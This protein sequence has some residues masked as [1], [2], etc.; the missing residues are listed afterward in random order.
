MQQRSL[1][2]NLISFDALMHA[3][4]RAVGDGA[5][6]AEMQQ[7]S[8]ASNLIS[9]DALMHA[10]RGGQWEMVLELLDEM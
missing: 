8:L 1:A 9:F 5:G 4:R 7:R 3:I 2:S 6:A 10:I